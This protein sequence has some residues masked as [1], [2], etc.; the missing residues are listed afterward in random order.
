MQELFEDEKPDLAAQLALDTILANGKEGT[1]ILDLVEALVRNCENRPAK[2][3]AIVRDKLN[4]MAEGDFPK[5]R[6]GE[7][8]QAYLDLKK[9]IAK[10]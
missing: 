7:I 5:S 3:K 9:E 6:G 8:S 4:K 10:L 1:L 2:I